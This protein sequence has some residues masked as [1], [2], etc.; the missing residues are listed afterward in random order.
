MSV[1]TNTTALQAVLETVKA[2]P[3][4]TTL[5]PNASGVKF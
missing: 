4:A 5:P 1:Q 3:S 2:L